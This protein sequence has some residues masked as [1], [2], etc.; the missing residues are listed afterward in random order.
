MIEITARLAIS[1]DDIEF[2]F[3]RASGPG[4]QNVNK[5][6]SAVQLRFHMA[7]SADLS[8]AVKDRL[9]RLAGRRLSLEGVIV[10]QAQRF[11]TQERNREDAIARLVELIRSATVVAPP[12][13]PTRPTLGSKERRLASKERRGQVKSLRQS[14]PHF[15]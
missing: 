6:S 1:E 15:D 10:I 5:V 13:R 7:R 2:V 4:G 9:A 12:R 14:K 8:D 11:R 3:V